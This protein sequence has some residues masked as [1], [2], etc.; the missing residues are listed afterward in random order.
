M[1]IRP[2]DND[3]KQQHP[4][5][6]I[7]ILSAKNIPCLVQESMRLQ[8]LQ[9]H[10]K[11]QHIIN[12]SPQLSLCAEPIFNFTT[13]Y[14]LLDIELSMKTTASAVKIYSPILIY[15]TR[16]DGSDTCSTSLV[17][18]AVLD[19]RYCM[20]YSADYISVELIPC[21]VDG[22]NMGI[23]A[24]DGRAGRAG[25]GRWWR[26]EFPDVLHINVTKIDFIFNQFP[27]LFDACHTT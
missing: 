25:N 10:V 18:T 24:G 2:D 6:L 27:L 21:E 13:K 20:L 7:E 15:L 3:N 9:L 1:D 5:L 17:A 26:F 16:S 14:S 4:E 8:S 11:F 23:G 22:T 19:F 12:R